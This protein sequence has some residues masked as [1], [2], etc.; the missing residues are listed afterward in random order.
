MINIYDRQSLPRVW[1]D[2]LVERDMFLTD[3]DAV[4]LVTQ[5][6]DDTIKNL[7]AWLQDQEE[8]KFKYVFLNGANMMVIAPQELATVLKLSLPL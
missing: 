1:K 6:K 4:L 7:E 8:K 3:N 2:Y 5:N